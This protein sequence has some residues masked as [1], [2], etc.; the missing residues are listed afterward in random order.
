LRTV[1]D[2]A[3]QYLPHELDNL[4]SHCLARDLFTVS[5]AMQRIAQPDMTTRPGAI[6]LGTAL[7]ARG[8][9]GD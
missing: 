7:R 3:P 8:D 4:I 2:I 6:L 5:E 9:S 1:I